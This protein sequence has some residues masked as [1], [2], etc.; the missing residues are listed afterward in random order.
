[1]V[2]DVVFVLSSPLHVNIGCDKADVEAQCCMRR[3]LACKAQ[4]Q[5]H[6]GLCSAPAVVTVIKTQKYMCSLVQVCKGERVILS[7]YILAI[8]GENVP[9]EGFLVL[10]G[11]LW[12]FWAKN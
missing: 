8:L 11:T 2:C 1:M 12:A 10:A 5:G 3:L 6:E 7:R 4:R 9:A